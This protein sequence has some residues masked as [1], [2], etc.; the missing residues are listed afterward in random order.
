MVRSI[1]AALVIL[2]IAGPLA[3]GDLSRS[4]PDPSLS[5]KDVVHIV[6]TALRH[7]DTPGPDRGI[8]V[9]F[10]FASP[11]NKQTTG[12][13]ARFKAM[14]KGP[15]Y[16]VMVGHRSVTYEKYNVSGDHARIDA[17]LV[18]ADGRSYGFR[19]GLTRQRGNRFEGFWMTDSVVPIEVVTL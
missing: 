10:G 1:L 18:A 14:V 12:P 4:A 11:A 7:N 3:A 8:E 17:V 5:P 9:T 16:G 6:M 2:V 19:F 15:A 13:F